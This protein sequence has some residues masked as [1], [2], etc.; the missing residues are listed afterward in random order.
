MANHP[1][2][3]YRKNRRHPELRCRHCSVKCADINSLLIHEYFCTPKKEPD[4]IPVPPAL[5]DAM[6]ARRQYR[7]NN[8]QFVKNPKW[9]VLAE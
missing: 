4:N 6:N 3:M 9:E 5:I 8:I 1:G 7:E 2:K